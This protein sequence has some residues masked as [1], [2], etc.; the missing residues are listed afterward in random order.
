MAKIYG[1]SQAE[2]EILS[3]C[4]S[5]I[6]NFKDIDKEHQKLNNQMKKEEKKFYDKLPERIKG[7]E[8]KLKDIDKEH[9]KLN[10]QMKKEEKKF[11]DKLPERIKGEEIKLKDI[12]NEKS[13]IENSDKKIEGF[14]RKLIYKY[15]I[16]HY[17][18]RKIKNSEINQRNI[19]T[20]LRESP[21][22][23]FN[24]EQKELKNEIEN[25]LRKIKNSE[26]NQR[27]ILTEL[28]ESPEDVFNR[29]QKELKNE[30]EKFD[31]I[32]KE[33]SYIG[34][35]GE[36]KVLNELLKLNDGYNV[37]C[38]LNVEL[39]DWKLYDDKKNLGSAQM[40]FVVVS[41][42]GVFP[43]E[44]K[45]W[46]TEYYNQHKDISP[47]EQLNRA[48]NVLW[49]FLESKRL[50]KKRII[51]KVLVPIRNNIPY[52]KKYK[53]VMVSSL[54]GLNSFITSKK[55]LL[56]DEDVKRI[57]ELFIKIIQ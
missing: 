24:R 20:E 10:N 33:P 45:N 6:G 44:V 21:E 52:N 30:I 38:D 35:D 55:E 18:L 26:I 56:S 11:Y 32:K 50:N 3:I 4:P 7:E 1:S 34:A 25:K 51:N 16:K 9:Q 2:K 8:I 22:D 23:V 47:H 29:E 37:F 53:F 39:D 54:N 17:K 27:N 40:D 15:I 19:L 43:I 48:G 49:Y 5:S 41:R 12:G 13:L 57:T 31:G 36:L 14:F 42:N 28:R 46:S